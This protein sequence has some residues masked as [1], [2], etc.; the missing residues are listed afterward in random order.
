MDLA[1]GMDATTA[2]LHRD[3]NRLDQFNVFD[4][5][6]LRLKDNTA[7]VKLNFLKH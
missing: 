7:I 3:I 6:I 4:R 2:F 5:F 1:M